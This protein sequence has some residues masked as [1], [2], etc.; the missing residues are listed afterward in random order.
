VH[1]FTQQAALNA[2]NDKYE[3]APDRDQALRTAWLSSPIANLSKW[4]SPVMIIHADD[5]RNVRFNQSV[6][7][8][9]RL[10]KRKVPMETLMI[11]DDT[12]HWMNHNNAV[13]VYQSAAEFFVKKLKP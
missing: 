10:T 8:I 4:T 5:D 11:P 9:N 6:D 2:Q 13:G 3:K 1:D 7:L 12:H